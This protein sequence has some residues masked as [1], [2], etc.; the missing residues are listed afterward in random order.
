[1]GQ[2]AAAVQGSKGSGFGRSWFLIF[3]FTDPGKSFGCR[4]LLHTLNPKP[5]AISF[6]SSFIVLRMLLLSLGVRLHT[7]SNCIGTNPTP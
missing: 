5:Q 6:L 7:V 3:G 2:V 4:R 1:M